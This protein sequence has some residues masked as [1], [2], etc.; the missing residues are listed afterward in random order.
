LTV[1]HVEKKTRRVVGALAHLRHTPIGR[2][3]QAK[4]AE[5]IRDGVNRQG[6]AVLQ[7]CDE[8]RSDKKSIVLTIEYIESIQD[9]HLVCACHQN[10]C[11]V[12]SFFFVF[13]FHKKKDKEIRTQ[14]QKHYM[15]TTQ[16]HFTTLYP[17]CA[18]VPVSFV[19]GLIALT[20]PA[21]NASHEI[22]A[23]YNL[24][25][26]LLLEIV[27][28]RDA[29]FH[30]FPLKSFQTRREMVQMAM[31]LHEHVLG[32]KLDLK[33]YLALFSSLRATE[34]KSSE[35]KVEQGCV[36]TGPIAI[37]N[38]SCVCSFT[39]TPHTE[40]HQ[41][42][43]QVETFQVSQELQDLG[44]SPSQDVNQEWTTDAAFCSC[45]FS[46]KWFLLHMI[47]SAF[48][49]EPTPHD[50][51]LYHTFLILFGQILA[52]FACRVNFSSNLILAHYHPSKTLKDNSTFQTFI[53]TLHDCVNS[54]L[55]KPIDKRQSQDTRDF[56]KRLSLLDANAFKGQI[57]IVKESEAF[58][59]FFIE[60]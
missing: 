15:A 10:V 40:E 4:R 48:P 58:G 1:G 26:H 32:E 28:I 35:A 2:R 18:F 54:M 21:K 27:P 39:R 51:Y 25:L 37:P 43:F 47:A 34:C 38:T 29:N 23:T 60:P 57:L 19:L 9:I 12:C 3:D 36:R 49:Q 50:H 5:R 44:M 30:S 6:L 59:R 24:W 41:K 45:L 17:T 55:R 13:V 7:Q 8:T 20:F 52:C 16:P 31:Q 14:K 56:L 33:E 46:C 11:C 53:E 22:I 42:T